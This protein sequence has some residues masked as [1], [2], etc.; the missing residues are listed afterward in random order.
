MYYETDPVSPLNAYGKSKL[1]GEQLIQEW[2]KNYLIL[3]T[4]WL[5]SLRRETYVLKV[6]RWARTQSTMRVVTDQSG[7]PTSARMLAEITALALGM[8]KQ[9]GYD[10]LE[11]RQGIY[12]LAGDGQLHATN[13]HRPFWSL[14]PNGKNK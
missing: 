11:K 4:S 10:W 1:L 2:G 14:I 12:H 8:V 9:G 13:L 6:L 7:S 3:R 5:Y